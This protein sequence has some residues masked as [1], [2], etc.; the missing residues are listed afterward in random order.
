MLDA[1]CSDQNWSAADWFHR[2]ERNIN[3]SPIEERAVKIPKGR[4]TYPKLKLRNSKG[5]DIRR[6]RSRWGKRRPSTDNPRASV[7]LS[8]LLERW[9]SRDGTWAHQIEANA[10][11][12]ARGKETFIT[13][14]RTSPRHLRDRRG[15]CA[16]WSGNVG[17][18][19]ATVDEALSIEAGAIAWKP[20]VE[21]EIETHVFIT[22]SCSRTGD[23]CMTVDLIRETIMPRVR[24]VE[25]I[26]R[27]PVVVIREAVKSHESAD[28]RR[29]RASRNQRAR[30]NPRTREKR[31]LVEIEVD[32]SRDR[33][34]IRSYN[35]YEWERER[36]RMGNYW[37][38]QGERGPTTNK[39]RSRVSLE[40][41]YLLR[42]IIIGI[43]F[44]SSRGASRYR[45]TWE[46]CVRGIQV[47]GER[48]KKRE[49]KIDRTGEELRASRTGEGGKRER[50]KGRESE[51]EEIVEVQG[52]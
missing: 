12:R 33:S 9:K 7:S 47:Q 34:I 27:G 49:R 1:D 18:E 45:E 38:D 10:C 29:A 48:K 11:N 23:T 39:K 37:L 42:T 19:V 20:S 28:H 44:G 50:W 26:S 43:Y 15:E 46:R 14:R 35:P 16:S 25:R 51:K 36:E 22:A 32:R 2:M 41:H 24:W 6:G 40:L 8:L 52:E 17:F 30:F 5:L 13:A 3:S 21:G 4:R 31:F